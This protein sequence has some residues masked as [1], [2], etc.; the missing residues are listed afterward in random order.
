MR[1]IIM[2]FLL[3]FVRPVAD[4]LGQLRINE[5]LAMNSFGAVNP[6]TGE[7][8]DW[9][10]IYNS[11]SLAVNLI[12]YFISDD[13]DNPVKW[14]FPSGIQIPAYGYLLVYAD[15]TDQ[16]GE[17]LH[18][19]FKLDATGEYILLYS[20]VNGMIDS[21]AFPRMY[22][23]ISY[24]L[25]K[26][27]QMAFF[28][29]PTPGKANDEAS[30]YQMA[31]NVYF[32]P[33]GGIYPTGT[34]VSLTGEPGGTIRYTTDGSEP[35]YS[36]MVYT[37]SIHVLNNKVIRARM[38]MDG[39]EPGE[40]STSSYLVHDPYSMPVVSLSTDPVNLWDDQM[41]I[42]VIGKN[43]ISG[44][45]S[46]SP[47]NW[48]QDWERPVSMEYFD[49]DGEFQLQMNGGIKIHGG[50]SR[51]ASLK[52][53]GIFARSEYGSSSMKYPFFREKDVDEFKGLILRNAGNDNQYT[54]IR[55]AVIQA[56]VSPVMDIDFQAY[57]PV[58]VYLNG[59][60]WGML[61]MREKV[62]EHWVTSNYGIPAENLDFLKNFY[63]EFAGSKDSFVELMDFMYQ[64]SLAVESNYDQ[65]ALQLDVNSYMDYLIT[66]MFFA[67]RDWPG[68]NQKYW[69]D[70]VNGTKWR[71]ILFDMEFSMGLYD[72]DPG[73]DMFEFSTL[74][75][76]TEWPNP[77][78]ATLPI[79]KLLENQGFREKFIQ[80]YMMYLN[81]ALSSENVIRVI[82][83]LY[84][85]VYD[86]M[87]DHI[88]R[89][90]LIPS[91]GTWDARVDELRQF[92]LQRPGHVR[93]NMRN[94]FSL[95]SEVDFQIAP[96]GNTGEVVANGVRVPREGMEGTY[97]AG[98]DLELNF[99]ASPG[100]K[101]KHWEVTSSQSTNAILFPRHSL[102]RYNDSGVYPGDGWKEASYDDSA[103]PSGQGE[104]GYGDGDEATILGFGTDDQNKYITS[105]FRTT[106]EIG[107]ISLLDQYTIRMMRDD[108]AVVYINGAEAFRDNM[109]AGSVLPETVSVTFAGGE[110]EYTYFEYSVDK[111]LFQQGTNT[112]AVEI[113][114]N[115][116]TSSDISF[117]LEIAAG[118]ESGEGTR[119]LE[120]NPLILNSG[121]DISVR[122]VTETVVLDL[123]L[124]IN[125]IMAS[126][127]GAF[128]DEYGNDA[129]WIEIYNAGTTD[130]DMAGLYFTDSLDI[131]AK[132]R[133]PSG[134]PSMTTVK[135]SDYLVFFADGNPL[136]GP[137]HLDFKLSATG[138]KVGLSY[139]SG[140]NSVW[141]DTIPY[142]T[143][144]TNISLGRYPDGAPNIVSMG[145]YTPGYSNV[146]TSV[147]SLPKLS[148]E[149][150]LY[151]NPVS[152]DLNVRV[153]TISGM[154]PDEIAVHLFD[155]TG[156]KI[157]EHRIPGWG[158]E[159]NES[160]DVSQLSDGV[161]VMV[162]ET[163]SGTH[164]VKFIK[165]AR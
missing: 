37:N 85:N 7:P 30:S 141:I 8:N 163:E 150:S 138:E 1:I 116:P 12:G 44:Y 114:Q 100:Y 110:D 56:T 124:Y 140:A 50:C 19:N 165:A 3:T 143:Q 161:Y 58:Q 156:R 147:L 79:R 92:A 18:A 15:G 57:E 106:L 71:F 154:A 115:S 53:F 137:L 103:W 76:G 4:L 132:W 135:A 63:E 66:E 11:S 41:G 31:G 70:R 23:N 105:Y 117:D 54:F 83:S 64:N 86:E 47:R 108:G 22:A 25:L 95:G 90:H 6:V 134:Y 69:R 34:T 13:P 87:P 89:W 120:G 10:E 151:P 146:N 20:A 111:N 36:D 127:L 88:A 62:N 121:T 60:Y 164:S 80:K 16:T 98:M 97:L 113:H 91:M 40:T 104:L 48:N 73:I 35:E 46:D 38:W 139:M 59:E 94:F 39:M 145:Y 51:Q 158:G 130:V 149:I 119:V 67:N 160:L 159:F 77:D 81:T 112:I 45:C 101:L 9:I 2:I 148:F 17:K 75:G 49:R 21:I 131:P 142:M 99:V 136:L 153:R 65:V 14:K 24:G 109:P 61:N 43:G 96:T 78:Y 129:D 33:P 74:E 68:N 26:N 157:M 27:G 162:I 123:D 52:S 128:L 55:D 155:I 32:D 152:D 5:L 82:D 144:L 102:W 107:D 126:N 72:F 93:N 28:N 84:Y 122:A 118:G 42:H 125:E 133:I 29:K